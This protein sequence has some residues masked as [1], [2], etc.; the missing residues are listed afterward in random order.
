MLEVSNLTSRYGRIEVLHEIS[1]EVREGE[2]VSLIGSN[3]A[4]KTTFLRALS[5]VQPVSG[6]SIHWQGRDISKVA[7]HL[8]SRMGVAQVP[9]GRQVFAPLSVEDN[10]KLGAWARRDSEIAP[11]MEN[12]YRMFPVLAEKRHIAAGSLSGGQQQML[13]VGRALMTKPKLL[14]LDEPSMGLA[15]LLVEQILASV[16][17]LPKLGVTVLLVEQNATAALAISNRAYVLETGKIILSGEAASL[18]ND[19]RVAQAYLGL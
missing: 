7:A 17:G 6:G 9:E 5:G 15:P 4:G 10:L 8:R 11:D 19:A 1:L 14:L 3:G 13:A 16:A 2:I 12:V 18:A